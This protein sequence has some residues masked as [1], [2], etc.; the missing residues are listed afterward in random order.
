MCPALS[1]MVVLWHETQTVGTI[2]GANF[3]AITSGPE[4]SDRSEE[5]AYFIT[6]T[7][8]VVAPDVY[9]EGSGSM[10]GLSS[11]FTL[12]GVVTG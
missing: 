1:E 8:L 6:K 3:V 12:D 5:R 9:E 2:E 10:W 4:I 11:S 7:G